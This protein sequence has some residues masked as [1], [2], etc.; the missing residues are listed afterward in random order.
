M[1][2]GEEVVLAVDLVVDRPV[3]V[4][5][6]MAEDHLDAAHLAEDVDQEE[7]R[8]EEG[9]QAGEEAHPGE[10]PGEIWTPRS[11][12]LDAQRFWIDRISAVLYTLLLASSSRRG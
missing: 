12:D 2:Q 4:E 5:M 9:R 11:G 6:E 1:N 7:G 10:T 3:E 8:Q